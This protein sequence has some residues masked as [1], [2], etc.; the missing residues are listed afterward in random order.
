[1]E[2]ASRQGG[3]I[4]VIHPMG[5]ADRAATAQPAARS[6]HQPAEP[7]SA[8][9]GDGF[10]L[11]WTSTVQKQ[12]ANY[13][14]AAT[15]KVPASRRLSTPT[16]ISLARKRATLAAPPVPFAVPAVR[17][18]ANLLSGTLSASRRMLPEPR[19]E[20]ALFAASVSKMNLPL[21]ASISWRLKRAP[22]WSPYVVREQQLLEASLRQRQE[23][24][25]KVQALA[26]SLPLVPNT[27]SRAP[28]WSSSQLGFYPDWPK[29][30]L[31][32]EGEARVRWTSNG[33]ARIAGDDE[34]RE[35]LG[36]SKGLQRSSTAGSL[37]AARAA[38]L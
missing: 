33:R 14:R 5:Q 37:W 10:D 25:L 2:A 31:R 16:T 12:L 38:Q 11:L 26:A 32:P 4:F 23:L 8:E 7:A 1:M 20:P 22:S 9:L 35:R 17:E 13:D 29:G 21:E 3:F 6:T 27:A 30:L 36:M 18:D 19:A 34:M 28:I 15:P 24:S